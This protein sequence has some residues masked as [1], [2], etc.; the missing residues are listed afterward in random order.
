[1]IDKQCHFTEDQL[2]VPMQDHTFTRC[3]DCGKKIMSE[4]KLYSSREGGLIT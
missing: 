3:L 2:T 1:M 4:E